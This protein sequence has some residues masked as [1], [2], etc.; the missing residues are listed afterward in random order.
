[1][2]PI[3]SVRLPDGKLFEIHID[4]DPEDPRTWDNFG[5]MVCW[6][7]RYSLGDRHDFQTPDDFME[8]WEEN[9]KDGVLLPLYLYD[10]SGI[11]MSTSSFRC[12]WDSGQV[13]YIYATADQ[14]MKEFG[15][16]E[17]VLDRIANRPSPE[18]LEKA[19]RLLKI[20]VETYDMYIRGDVYGF[21]IKDENGTYSD[22]CWGYYGDIKESGILDE[23]TPEGREAVLAEL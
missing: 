7:R 5:T 9:G 23:L 6:H 2:E 21:T 14:I 10:H 20:E 3:L 22:S 13:G 17:T 18:M 11:T 15:P 19:K 8:W 4:E 16:P 12:P 1:M